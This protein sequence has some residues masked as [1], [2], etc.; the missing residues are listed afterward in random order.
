MAPLCFP[1]HAL[2][3]RAHAHAHAL[4]VRGVW[5]HVRAARGNIDF[6]FGITK[7]RATQLGGVYGVYGVYLDQGAHKQ[8]NTSSISLSYEHPSVSQADG[9]RIIRSARR[10]IFPCCL[11]FIR[12][13]VLSIDRLLP[14]PISPKQFLSAFV[15]LADG[16]WRAVRQANGSTAA[17]CGGL[18]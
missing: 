8:T 6:L 1:R 4:A 14:S 3:L 12:L 5:R 9:G 16:S 2:S 7:R 11:H 15:F 13:L 17:R 18:V 10:L